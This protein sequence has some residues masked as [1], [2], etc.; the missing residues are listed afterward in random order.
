MRRILVLLSVISI[1]VLGSMTISCAAE[2]VEEA[3][4]EEAEEEAVVEEEAEEEAVVEEE[5]EI[6]P[7]AY[8]NSV[9]ETLGVD[10][11]VYAE[12]MEAVANPS[13]K[14]IL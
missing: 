13:E 5:I 1:I 6:D 7:I 4:V 9:L 10:T 8:R 2:A 12:F 11:E 3:V 14:F